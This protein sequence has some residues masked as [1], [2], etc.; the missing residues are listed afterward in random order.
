M[1]SQCKV[2]AVIAW[3]LEW[4]LCCTIEPSAAAGDAV[5]IAATLFIRGGF[6]KG[7]SKTFGVFLLGSYKIWSAGPEPE[8]R[9]RS[10]L[11]A[12]SDDAGQLR[13][14]VLASGHRLQ[15]AHNQHAILDD[16]PKDLRAAATVVTGVQEKQSP[17]AALA[18]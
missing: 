13:L 15:L 10:I 12:L 4:S 17:R 1:A 6:F 14:V 11:P 2:V 7:L 9:H 5:F 16:P 8:G 18:R 3:S